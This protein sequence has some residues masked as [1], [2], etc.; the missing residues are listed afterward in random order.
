MC[1]INAPFFNDEDSARGY[2]EGQRWPTG[3][4]CPHCGGCK[5]I[6]VVKADEKKEI[7]KGLYQCND[8]K[9]QFTVTV[10]TVF[11]RSKVP[12]HKWLMTTYLMSSSKKGISAKQIE[13]TVG[14]TY[15]TAWFMCHRIR[16]AMREGNP[17]IMGGNGIKVEADETF[18]TRRTKRLHERKRPGGHKDKAKVFTLVERNGRVRSFHVPAVNA[19]TLRPII[20]EQIAKDTHL[21]TDKASLYVNSTPYNWF[22][23]K[24]EER[25]LL[26]G[27]VDKHDYV[28][29]SIGEYV[30]GDI[31]TN[32]IEGYFSIFKRG[33]NGIYQHCSPKHLKRYLCEYDFR[34][35]YR[36]KLGY[37][38]MARTNLALQGI[39]GK[40][41]MYRDS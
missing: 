3:P 10:G 17:G 26:T 36:E 41:L 35:N 11:E 40:R 14:V 8:C 21:I 29:H 31:H 24:K 13:R 39:E 19:Q 23:M 4:V 34:Y 28:N 37:D 25:S 30:R 16:E 22:N 38:D 6:Y 2:L 5:R 1:D 32:T 33:L 18:I 27:L 9:Q 7:R 20:A 12:L 15:K